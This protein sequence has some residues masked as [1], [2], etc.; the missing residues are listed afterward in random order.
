METSPATCWAASSRVGP[1]DIKNDPDAEDEL[2]QYLVHDLK[3]SNGIEALCEPTLRGTRGRTERV[4]GEEAAVS[5]V[6]PVA[7]GD[8]RLSIDIDLQQAMQAAFAHAQI[9]DDTGKVVEEG[10]VLHGAE[11]SS[12]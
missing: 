11:S 7:G 10:A 4:I 9:R 12:T 1:D 8:V 2:R 3:G 6:E 5:S